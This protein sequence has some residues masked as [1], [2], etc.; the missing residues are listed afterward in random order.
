LI[1]SMSNDYSITLAG[2]FKRAIINKGGNVA[3]DV[4]LWSENTANISKEDSS[5]EFQ[6]GKIKSKSPDAV[7]YTGDPLE[8]IKIV[9]EMRRQGIKAPLIGGE[10]LITENFIK[11][12]K[13]AIIGTI[14]YSGF[15]ADSQLPHIKGFVDSYKKKHGTYPDRIAALGYDALKMTAEAIRKAPSMRPTHIRDSLA[16]IK[17]FHGAT[18]MTTFT[19]NREVK[20]HAYILKAEKEGGKIKFVLAGGEG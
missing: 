2:L 1:S 18:G 12:G 3:E 11:D 14:I 9:K 7:V 13:D 4:F 5:I 19:A 16:G 20:K 15:Y 6:V 17:D 10:E 8:G